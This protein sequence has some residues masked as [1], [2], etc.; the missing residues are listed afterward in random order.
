MAHEGAPHP[1]EEPVPDFEQ[2]LSK[3]SNPELLSSLASLI[4]RR[5]RSS[6]PNSDAGYETALF[7]NVVEGAS[8]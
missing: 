4:L 8:L 6:D 2:A 7:T 3:L 5:I 1:R